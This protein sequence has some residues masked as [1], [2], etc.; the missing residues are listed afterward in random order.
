MSEV[1]STLGS[2]PGSEY[3]P[4]SPCYDDIPSQ[5]GESRS[6][7]PSTPE[8]RSSTSPATEGSPVYRP[9]SPVE[10]EI[11]AERQPSSPVVERP[12]PLRQVKLA[13]ALYE[14]KRLFVGAV[15]STDIYVPLRN[16]TFPSEPLH[17][18]TPNFSRVID[19]VLKD[20]G[21]ADYIDDQVY[22]AARAIRPN[23]YH[24]T[25]LT[26][27][28]R[29]GTISDAFKCLTTMVAE[30][31]LGK[32]KLKL[33]TARIS[34]DVLIARLKQFNKQALDM[35]TKH[36]IVVKQEA[37]LNKH[38]AEDTLP[39]SL[40]CLDK[41]KFQLPELPANAEV[42]MKAEEL[43]ST[44]ERAKK[45]LVVAQRDI[46]T[47][48]TKAFPAEYIKM[49]IA[50]FEGLPE[51]L[52]RYAD[53][54]Q[55]WVQD[56]LTG[57]LGNN[58]QTSL[59]PNQANR[60]AII[61]AF[62]SI[63]TE[64]AIELMEEHRR[65]VS[66]TIADIAQ[67]PLTFVGTT[68]DAIVA[69]PIEVEP[70]S[71][72]P[73]ITTGLRPPP[74]KRKRPQEK[75]LPSAGAGG[76]EPVES[77]KRPRKPTEDT[78]VSAQLE[79]ADGFSAEDVKQFMLFQQWRKQAQV[80]QTQA[81]QTQVRHNTVMI[82]PAN[83][84]VPETDQERPRQQSQKRR[85]PAQ[86]A[87]TAINGQALRQ[88][89][90]TSTRWWKTPSEGPDDEATRCLRYECMNDWELV[91]TASLKLPLKVHNLARVSTVT[92]QQLEVLNYGLAFI[93]THNTMNTQDY[94]RC[95]EELL[96]KL[97]WKI[98]GW[99]NNPDPTLAAL[100]QEE[101]TQLF[102]LKMK[103][104]I[105]KTSWPNMY[106]FNASKNPHTHQVCWDLI[107][108]ALKLDKLVPASEVEHTAHNL[109]HEI[110]QALKLL[111]N[112]KDIVVVPADKNLGPVILDTSE[113]VNAT[114]NL[115][116]QDSNFTEIQCEYSQYKNTIINIFLRQVL[117]PQW[118]GW[119]KVNTEEAHH[120][121]AY[122]RET[123]HKAT[124]LATFYCI[125]K[126]H[127]TPI[128][129]RPIVPITGTLLEPVAKIVDHYLQP[130]VQNTHTFLKNS[131]EFI[132]EFDACITH[133]NLIP[134]KPKPNYGV[135][136][137]TAD[138]VNLYPSIPQEEACQ[139]VKDN[140]AA[141]MGPHT[142]V[143]TTLAEV[144]LRHNVVQLF[145]RKFK[146]INGVATGSPLAPTTANLYLSKLEDPVLDAF[147]HHVWM[148]RYIDDIFGLFVGTPNQRNKFTTQLYA[149]KEC[150]KLE[151]KWVEV[152]TLYLT[153]EQQRPTHNLTSDTIIFLDV[154]VNVS[155]LVYCQN[156]LI[157]KP[158]LI[159]QPY[160]K[161]LNNYVY[162]HP[163]SC[164]PRHVIIG[165]V[166]G[167]LT[168]F[169]RLSSTYD[170]FHKYVKLL[171]HRLRDRGY[172]SDLILDI[173][174]K[175]QQTIGNRRDEISL[176]TSTFTTLQYD[177][178]IAQ[179]ANA[180]ILKKI[181]IKYSYNGMT[182]NQRVTSVTPTFKV[183]CNLFRLLKPG[184]IKHLNDPTC[185]PAY[186]AGG[187]TKG[188]SDHTV[189]PQ[190]K[191]VLGNMALAPQHVPD[192]AEA[193][194]PILPPLARILRTK[195]GLNPPVPQQGSP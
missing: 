91:N 92:P 40:R 107:A 65:Q 62:K 108:I 80:K 20:Q 21:L 34:F 145:G 30:N 8:I 100:R 66:K 195:T 68:K 168:R 192:Q 9:I 130:I 125:P 126:I 161:E 96:R 127:K 134:I 73:P 43:D 158:T 120:L 17:P 186:E 70:P 51:E 170:I 114:W 77:N 19:K 59:V 190:T 48:A 181:S 194:L 88:F 53:D 151:W 61:E 1:P 83:V 86:R 188:M 7:S 99:I 97:A 47:Q 149:Q 33:A 177:G 159:Y 172:T 185:H 25:R 132:Q 121:I 117:N 136:L 160:Q 54:I 173:F 164:H 154:Q 24:W 123:T 152:P 52:T 141:H 35:F 122:L 131:H 94:H 29:V 116:H 74:T 106:K 110:R 171:Y 58:T 191:P 31:P 45:S 39:T 169:K 163:N 23:Q 150:I 167:E 18:I 78:G 28:Q 180:N 76:G 60:T 184:M 144:A 49:Q 44:L 63:G 98:W 82:A 104:R 85:R 128:K 12:V 10:R 13:R 174:V 142:D 67:H 22:H 146:Q 187:D 55:K 6:F 46:F 16:F 102:S 32:A 119:S 87:K 112:N 26:F 103:F 179:Q 124:Q 37:K 75:P 137:F 3:S 93:P 42:A 153:S 27:A 14:A 71:T 101:R 193:P 109:P 105:S 133:G 69:T 38:I 140:I 183:G 189:D 115:L 139:V 50:M 5:A 135:W 84:S 41:L 4:S 111:V 147:K 90:S 89:L 166:R 57:S 138:V 11:T 178:T 95:S 175:W 129:F 182:A 165:W 79:S 64:F 118:I 148:K 15:G 162:L 157:T 81:K 113:Y 56:D 2:S 155:A 156:M 36:N 143:L 176:N 72:H